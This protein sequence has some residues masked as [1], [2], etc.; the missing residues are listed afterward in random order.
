MNQFDTSSE[1]S[2]AG[3]G[4]D[5]RTFRRR[6]LLVIVHKGS[7]PPRPPFGAAR[8]TPADDEWIA[9]SEERLELAVLAL[10]GR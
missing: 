1:V 8:P 10:L 7:S 3:A 6:A 5:V 2:P 9:A 4:G